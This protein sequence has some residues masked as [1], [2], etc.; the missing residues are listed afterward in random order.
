[1]GSLAR[2]LFAP[3][4]SAS[5]LLTGEIG[6]N[7][8]TAA[9]GLRGLILNAL[10]A[11][12]TTAT[13]RRVSADDAATIPAVYRGLFL[14]AS[15]PAFLPL[16]LYRARPDGGSD[17]ARDHHAFRL[18]Y[19][20]PNAWQT[21][22]QWR[23]AMNL[24]MHMRGDGFSALDWNDDGTLAAIHWLHPDRVE[25]H[26]DSDGN[27]VY[28]VYRHPSKT[29]PKD[30]VWVSRF[31]MHHV[32]T[33]T[34]NGY[35]GCS[36]L[37]KCRESVALTLGQREVAER[38][39]RNGGRPSG[40]LAIPSGDPE[41]KAKSKL[42]WE[43]A[44]KGLGN[45][46]NTAVIW[47]EAKYYP[48]TFS[49]VDAQWLEASRLSKEEMATMLGIPPDFLT[50]S[51]GQMGGVTGVEQRFMSFLATRLDP[52]LVAHE[53]AIQRDILG[54]EE[55]DVV[56]PR[57]TRSAFL[58]T[59]I[60]TRYRVYAQG[61]QWGILN[62]DECRE[63]EELN[64]RSDGGGKEYLTPAAYAPPGDTGQTNAATTMSAAMS[65]DPAVDYDEDAPTSAAIAA[66]PTP[67]ADPA[68]WRPLLEQTLA[69]VYRR[70]V[71]D[72]PAAQRRGTVAEWQTDHRHY[73]A[74]QLAPVAT[75]LRGGVTLAA[76]DVLDPTTAADLDPNAHAATIAARMLGLDTDTED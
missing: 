10:T 54:P 55:L 5:D 74:D 28:R 8:W 42:S 76:P 71:Q 11:A 41:A 58:R 6:E 75:T 20:Q 34:L 21:S 43:E 9:G 13:G 25:V 46:G 62:A 39:M 26:V 38:L 7:G 57:Y 63:L 53:Q 56:Y 70:A 15:L 16:K 68:A 61:R 22:F 45:V 47:A 65:A 67:P 69:R 32:W 4:R 19:S 72:L 24:S 33:E 29:D 40:V 18:L 17:P 49:M 64:P 60:L 2:A 27:P 48:I 1:M 31:N 73:L 30:A 44:H 36:A 35:T 51:G 3:A 23:V 12:Q 52:I 59:D 14:L 50:I 37:E 66:A